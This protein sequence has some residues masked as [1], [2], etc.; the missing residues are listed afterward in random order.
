MRG[1]W[2]AAQ[3]RPDALYYSDV[4]WM[5]FYASI[6]NRREIK[7]NEALS[8]ELE[9]HDVTV[10]WNAEERSFGLTRWKGKTGT[11]ELRQCGRNYKT[12]VVRIARVLK[13]FQ[14]EVKETLE[15]RGIE[16]TK[17]EG[18]P[19]VILSLDKSILFKF[20]PPPA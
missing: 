1:E 12:T 20:S 2:Q 11:F 19:M 15:F 10:L 4:R 6:N 17:Y 5:F 8:G 3:G 7:M 16:L 18:E 14:I 9:A 13:E